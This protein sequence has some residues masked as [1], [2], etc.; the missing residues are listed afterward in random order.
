MNCSLRWRQAE[1][2][3]AASRIDVVEAEHVGKE[4]AIGLGIAAEEDEVRP[5]D[6]LHMFAALER[7]VL[8][9]RQSMDGFDRSGAGPARTLRY[10]SGRSGGAMDGP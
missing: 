7:L 2:Q 10:H 5:V 6:H 1:D 3:P 4:G 9:A 8:A